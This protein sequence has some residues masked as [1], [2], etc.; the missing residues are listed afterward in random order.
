MTQKFLATAEL[1]A[2]SGFP[3]DSVLNSFVFETDDSFVPSSSGLFI[4]QAIDAFYDDPTPTNGP[5]GGFIN[6]TRS[7]GAGDVKVKLF[8]ITTSLDGTAHG[9]PV[10]EDALT[11]PAAVS[12]GNLPDEVALVLT[13][14]GSDAL[15]QPVEA[16]DGADPGTAIDRPRQRKSGRIY[17]GPLT[18]ATLDGTLTVASRPT[19]ALM[20]AVL[21]G[22]D[23]LVAACDLY[24]GALLQWCTWSR[25]NAAVYPITSVSVDNAF[26][27]QRRRGVDATNR[28]I[29]SF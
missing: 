17:V 7:R 2:V 27:I 3:E 28:T 20:N 16:P 25:A 19:S 13:L 18:V 15:T 8:D 21:E 9:S 29:V 12:S 23:A 1:T 11:L 5:V 6:G 10:Y 24:G 14:R 4:A 22:A 26:D